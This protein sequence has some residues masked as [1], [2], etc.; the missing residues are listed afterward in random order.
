[1]TN[2]EAAALIAQMKELTAATH[3]NAAATIA[4]AIIATRGVREDGDVAAIY[5]MV[6]ATLFPVAPPASKSST[7]SKPANL[8]G[9]LGSAARG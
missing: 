7:G 3:A 2:T 4:A 8:S 1:L 9:F 6:H 5:R